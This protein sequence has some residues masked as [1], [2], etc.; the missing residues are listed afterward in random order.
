MK[1]ILLNRLLQSIKV[2]DLKNIEINFMIFANSCNYEKPIVDFPQST[3]EYISL[4]GD[5]SLEIAPARDFLQ[6]KIF[7]YCTKE[8][9]KP[10]VWLLDEDIE[11]DSRANEYLPKLVHLREKGNDIL[12]GSIEGDSPNASFSGMGVQLFDLIENFKWLDSLDDNDI[13]P[14]RE[15]SNQALRDK[16]PNYYYDLSS[17]KDK[18]YLHI[19]FWLTP[20]HKNERVKEAKERIY[21][22]LTNILSGKNF[23]RTIKQPKLNEYKR[24]LLRGANTFV[25]NIDVLRV[26][27]PI[28]KVDNRTIRRSD[29]L[30]AL[31]NQE[32][33]NSQIIK[34]DFTV[35]HKR[36]NS[37]KI[38]LS[39]DKTVNEL[40]GSIVFNALRLF[41]ENKEEMGFEEILK[42]Q[43][44]TKI[45]AV[46][47]SFSRTKEY[48]EILK[49]FNKLELNSFCKALES[50]YTDKNFKIILS[51]ID[52]VYQFKEN[53]LKKFI[54]Y[55]PLILN[56]CDLTTTYYG[57]FKQYDLGDDKIKI[58]SI[59]SIEEM[60]RETPPLV[61]VHSSCC[62]SEVFHANDCDCANQL[63]EAMSLISKNKNGIIFYL[64][65]EGRGHGYSK[66]IAIVGKM[67][68]ESLDTYQSCQA[69]G[70]EK[71]IREYKQVTELLKELGFTKIRLLSN[72]PRKIKKI[73]DG[74]IEVIR[75]KV[76]GRYTHQNIDYLKSKQKYGGH[77]EI[78]VTQEL[79]NQKYIATKNVIEFYEKEDEYGIFSNF[80][81]HPFVLDRKYWRTS[82]H[83]YQANKFEMFSEIYN[84]IQQVKTPTLTKEIAHSNKYDKEEWNQKKILFMYNALYEKFTQNDGL[85]EILLTTKKNYIVEKAI[86]DEFWGSGADGEGKNML[87]KLLMYLRDEFLDKE[88]ICVE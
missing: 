82:E 74:G 42:Q 31:A 24:S 4:E 75:E 21:S 9:K 84:A 61:R 3:I 17:D 85:K 7:N 77:S 80:S 41:Y 66:K 70:L 1:S 20:I 8:Q 76:I 30:W 15:K 64:N 55:K 59:N 73:E 60:D 43:I 54:S 6:Q 83:Y 58:L 12:I 38:E 46:K 63:E 47:E 35:L 13:L 27:Q 48:I 5:K 49:R 81:D 72:N 33:L 23:F 56:D 44:Q 19:A 78:V 65:Q 36:E 67:Q 57:R 51:E 86:D 69:L 22:N 16:Y 53:I 2:V 71:D 62:N 10:I 79:L 88:V 28:I 40:A 52:K 14:Y 11:I 50:F 29:M 39:I 18:E 45:E 34:V 37:P 87:G 32:Y 25:L 68:K 26:K